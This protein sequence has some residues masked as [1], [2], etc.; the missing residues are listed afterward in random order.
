VHARLAGLARQQGVTVFMVV[1]AALAVLLARLGAGVDIPVG[2]PTAGRTDAAL[3]DLVGFFVNAL[4][5]RTDVAGDPSFTEL[6]GRVR[7]RWLG[8]LE[9]QDVPFEYLVEVLAPERSMG[10]HPLF[11]V[12]LGVQNNAAAVLELP[13]LRAEPVPAGRTQARFDLHVHLAETSGADG[14]PAGI[15]GELTAAADLFDQGT[16]EAIVARLV[17][18]LAVVTAAP[19]IRVREVEVLAA[20]EREQILRGWNNT[21]ALTPEGAVPEL[22][23]EMAVRTPDTVA[24]ACGDARV[25]YRE[26]VARAARL[27]WV[28]AGAGAGPEQVVGLCLP[29]GA[30]MITAMLAAWL[31]GAAYLPVDPAYPPERIAFMLADSRAVLVAGTSAT[32]DMLPGTV[33]VIR[34]DDPAVVAAAGPAV[35]STAGPVRVLRSGQLAYVIYTSGST[36][37]PKGVGVSQAALGNMAVALRPALGAGPGIRAL[38]FASFSFDASVLDVAVVLAAGGTLVV[39]T[40]RQRAEPGLVTELIGRCAVQAA[41]VVPSLLEVLD[42]EGVPGL[43]SV[44]AGAEPLPERLAEV[45]GRERRLVHAYGP[46]EATVIVTT[47]AVGRGAPQVPPIGRPVANMRVF[48]LDGWLGPVPAGVTGE[49]YVAGAQLARGYAGRAGL[50]AERFAACP[51]A[52]GVRMYRT[53]DLARWR[54]DGQLEFA[55]RADDQVKIRGFRVEPSEVEAVLAGHPE[56][57]QVAVAARQDSPGD[58][59]LVAY[60]VPAGGREEAIGDVA[61]LAAA[62][63]EFAADRLPQYM[64]PSAVAVLEALPLTPNGKVNRAALPAPQYAGPASDAAPRD[65]REAALCGVFAEVLRV[66]RVGVHDSFFELGGHSLL[67]VRLVSRVRTVLGAEIGVRAVFDAPTVAELAIRIGD[68]KNARPALRPRPRQEES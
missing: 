26:L 51:F 33:P 57:G 59:R 15:R 28:L 53:G 3:E 52:A 64:V 66:E 10:R 48:V 46:T 34:L 68:R 30:E 31:A 20:V 67:A 65:E 36:G 58:A 1:Q 13:G 63:R 22:V 32:A 18:V 9:H 35:P 21:A 17:R 61:G 25:S 4:V 12:M 44:V 6:L 40:A 55:G 24:V 43:T 42:A 23:A 54:A 19:G 60:V 14:R 47:A 2:V 11:Q 7:E 37:T 50:T 8:A 16:V 49:L 27:A 62:V 5:L 39:A 29:R 41:S 56:A 38:Q 45:W